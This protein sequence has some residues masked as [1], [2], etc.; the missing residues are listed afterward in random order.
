VGSW[1]LRL[2]LAVPPSAPSVGAFAFSPD[3]EIWAIGA[4]P[5]NTQLY[6]TATGQRLAILES[7]RPATFSRLTFSPDGAALAILQRDGAVQLW[8]LRQIRQQLAA[9]GLDWQQPSYPSAAVHTNV[10]PIRIEFI[11]DPVVAERRRFL[12][13]EIPARPIETD[14]RLIDLS[15]FYNATLRESWY[16]RPA[17][18]DLSDLTP[19]VRDLAG[20]PFDV[21]GLI[22][23][24]GPWENRGPYRSFT[25]GIRVHQACARLHFL[26]A[27]ISGDKTALGTQIGAYRLHYADGRELEIPIVLGK[28]VLDC[29]SQS[30]E[31]LTNVVVAWAGQNAKGKAGPS[32]RLF[33]TTWNNLF[34]S[35]PIIRIDFSGGYDEA[36][37]FL[38]AITAE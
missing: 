2:N 4:P 37:P 12:A 36:K 13:S 33:K 30:Q 3:G 29:F 1:E 10:K 22:Q 5:R 7:P 26:H 19:G 35:L 28:D 31:S 25:G 20:V 8:A 24:G 17:G 38:V 14:A 23:A 15:A 27:A 6:S 16:E 21:R 9:I 32:A 34:P 18:Y 11:D